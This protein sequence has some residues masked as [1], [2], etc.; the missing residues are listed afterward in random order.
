MEIEPP[1]NIAIEPP[2][3]VLSQAEPD[4]NTKTSGGNQLYR[5]E[6]TLKSSYGKELDEVEP[7]E[8]QFLAQILSDFCK[9]YYFQLE[10]ADSGYEHFQGC[11][12]LKVKHRRSEIKNIIGFKN[13]HLEPAINWKALV[14]Y[15]IKQDTRIGGPW[16]HKSVW[17]SVIEKLNWW[18]SA[19]E[20]TLLSKPDFRTIY[21]LWDSKGNIGKSSFSKYA[22]VKLGATVLNNGSFSDLA[23]AIPENPKIIIF[24]LPRTIEGRV[25]YTAIESLKNGMIFSGKYESR[26]KIFNAPHIFVFANF[27]PDISS[28]SADRWNIIEL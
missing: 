10:L 4:G 8:P 7:I 22:A 28:M 16:D 2:E 24:D 13:V 19:V 21:W 9:E 11:F 14:N 12:S 1:D 3:A 26:T 20:E 15:S 5:W 17:V 27:P 18:Q 6:F 23:F 25:N